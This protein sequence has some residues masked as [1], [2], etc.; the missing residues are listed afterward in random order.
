M[1]DQRFWVDCQPS[2]STAMNV[3]GFPWVRA[4][5][6][7]FVWEEVLYEGNY[8]AVH[9]SAVGRCQSKE[10]IFSKL[11]RNRF[12]REHLYAFELEVDGEL[13]RDGWQWVAHRTSTTTEGFE[14]LA[15]ELTFEN[16]PLRVTVHTQ[17]DG[18]EFLVRWLEI[19]NESTRPMAFARICPWAGQ[20]A[21]EEE[22]TTI[23]ARG[24]DRGYSVGRYR[25]QAWG[26]EGEFIWE[27]MPAGPYAVPTY[28]NKHHPPLVLLRNE[29]LGEIT[30]IHFECTPGIRI[31]FIPGL[32]LGAGGVHQPWG[33][34]AVYARAGLGGKAPLRIVAPGETIVTP[35]VHVA[36][37]K[38]DL[39]AVVNVLHDHLHASVIPPQPDGLRHLVEYNHT[40]YTLNAQVSKELLR[41]E[42][43]MAAALGIELFLVDA[44]WFGPKDKGWSQV[45]GDWTENQI[46]GHGGLM[47]VFD[48]ARA[49]GMKCGLWMP[50]EWVGNE[51]PVLR[52]HP[53]WFLAGTNYFNILRPE[54]EAHVFETICKAIEGFRL[55]CYRIDG[56]ASDFGDLRGP[57]GCRLEGLT[58]RYYETLYALY[59]RVRRRFP[60][61]IMENCCGGGG[62]CDLAMMRRFHYTQIT[63]NWDPP[64]QI[65]ILNGMTIGLAPA[66][67]MPLV[68]SINM[69]TADLDFVIR[70]GMLGHFTVS[71][72]FPRV[73]RINPAGMARWRH[74]IE[75][76]K[77]S[78]RPWLS[79]CRVYHHTPLQ[80]F[81]QRGQWVVLEYVSRDALQALIAVF[82][83]E[84]A[85][86]DTFPLVARGLDWGREYEVVHDSRGQVSRMAGR[87]L[88]TTGMP[89]RVPAPLESE[90]L[91]LRAV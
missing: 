1:M 60:N 9:H 69:R 50:P 85:P 26:M 43:E 15:V 65:R 71:G 36:L 58:W 34:D 29:T 66:Q 72:A 53:D 75:L 30:A 47:E 51:A 79:G 16:R 25:N 49:R 2:V 35:R 48:E 83:L 38:G 46:L 59:E 52:A 81:R 42:V 23:Y 78:I 39:D 14:E 12:P 91:L 37:V 45:V 74:G 67:C 61:L 62:R 5:A 18:S 56:G 7:R 77:T 10:N 88:G 28:G 32:E 89:V 57:D 27:P 90:L 70:T 4:D 40:G 20:V 13:L 73:D 44:G 8:L 31:E 6:G 84:N 22:G 17:L 82:R 68:G 54:V 64:C 41:E 86:S 21:C 33:H 3:P 87:D 55:D 63:D 76:Y 24:P 11:V 19:R 80:D